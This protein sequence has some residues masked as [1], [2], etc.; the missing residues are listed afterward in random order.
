MSTRATG[1]WS[2]VDCHPAADLDVVRVLIAVSCHEV[3]DT[4]EIGANRAGSCRLVARTD[5]QTLRLVEICR[6][7]AIGTTP[8]HHASAPALGA[9]PRHHDPPRLAAVEEWPTRDAAR[10]YD[11]RDHR[12]VAWG[13]KTV[14]E[15]QS[16]DRMG[17]SPPRP[18]RTGSHPLATA[19]RASAAT[20]G[21]CHDWRP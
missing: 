9:A 11:S 7:V 1:L 15:C 19:I 3:A 21:S 13:G 2:L 10:A 20:P 4:D 16:S 8:R 17:P 6:V 14:R 5:R 12:L 18:W